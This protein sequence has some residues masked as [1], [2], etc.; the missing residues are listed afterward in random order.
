MSRYSPEFIEARKQDLKRRK[1][2]I[3]K[4]LATISEFDEA[5]GKYIALQPEYDEGSVEDSID[6]GVEAEALQERVSRVDDLDKSLDEIKLALSKIDKGTYGRC[7]DTGEWI[8][9]E[10][11][12]TY[13]AARTRMDK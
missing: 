10:R 13:P 12:K 3:E 11:L 8:S 1:A 7:E 5:S 4:E 2:E 9:E 6:S